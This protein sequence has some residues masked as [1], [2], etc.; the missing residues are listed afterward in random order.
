[1]DDSVRKYLAKIGSR[2]GSVSK[3]VL[4]PR[5]VRAMVQVRE[6]RRAYRD[7]HAQCFWSYAPTLKITA[8]DIPWV[9]EQLMKQGGREAWQRGA[10]LCRHFGL[11]QYTAI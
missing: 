8:A 3:R 10:S 6:A 9:A 1:M 7:F 2:G 5:D 4:T 11:T